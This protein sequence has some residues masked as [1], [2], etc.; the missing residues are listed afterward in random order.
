VGTTEK[1]T[2]AVFM[3]VNGQNTS[4]EPVA[5]SY[6]VSQADAATGTV[7]RTLPPTGPSF[8]QHLNQPLP[9]VITRDASAGLASVYQVPLPGLGLT[10][11]VHAAS[12]AST[13]LVE[14]RL[15]LLRP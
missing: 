4:T 10:V 14:H 15:E 6:V 7:V 8:T 12:P 2:E 1:F 5:N 13:G 3:Q 9:G 11:S